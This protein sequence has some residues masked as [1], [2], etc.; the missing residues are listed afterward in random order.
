MKRIFLVVVGMMSPLWAAIVTPT[1]IYFTSPLDHK[2]MVIDRKSGEETPID[3]GDFPLDIIQFRDYGYIYYKKGGISVMDLES[4]KLIKKIEIPWDIKK[5][6]IKGHHAFVD[7]FDAKQYAVVDL[8][9][10]RIVKDVGW[11][12]DSKPLPTYKGNQ[13][14]I[15]YEPDFHAT[16]V[17]VHSKTGELVKQIV[18]DRSPGSIGIHGKYGYIAHAFSRILTIIDLDTNKID[19][20]L[21]I[22]MFPRSM[23]VCG[24]WGYI[25]CIDDKIISKIDLKTNEVVQTIL[26]PNGALLNQSDTDLYLGLKKI[27]TI[28]RMNTVTFFEGVFTGIQ[29]DLF[30]DE[31]SAFSEMMQAIDDG[32]AK[33]ARQFYHKALSACDPKACAIAA[34]AYLCGEYGAIADLK[35]YIEFKAEMDQDYFSQL[36]EMPWVIARLPLTCPREGKF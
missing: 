19:K 20:R 2:V 28:D 18:I 6:H 29:M 14:Y 23:L 5:V 27:D 34:Y 4:S 32:D 17:L 24:D 21:T 31:E 26:N 33:G 22:G 12:E 11:I 8:L 9:Q 7:G 1:H 36:C 25:D 35:T 3:V 15:V 16:S 30:T 13:Y 10:D